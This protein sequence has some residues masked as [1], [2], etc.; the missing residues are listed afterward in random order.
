MTIEES[1][2]HPAP[3]FG[4]SRARIRRAEEHLAALIMEMER[5]I[6]ENPI[7][8]TFTG[9]ANGYPLIEI[10]L[11]GMGMRFGILFGDIVHSLRSSL[12]LMASEL[13]RLAGAKDDKVYFPFAANK[14]GFAAQI[15]Q[16]QFLSCGQDAV[17]L[18]QQIAPYKGGNDLLRALHDFDIRDKHRT[19]LVAVPTT[20]FSLEAYVELGPGDVAIRYAEPHSDEFKFPKDWPLAG[21]NIVSKLEEM[22]VMVSGIISKF[23]LM[24]LKRSGKP[25]AGITVGP[26]KPFGL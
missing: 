20:K 7:K 8:V 21:E 16:K 3:F 14:A 19:L 13:A 1:E 18:L 10:G 9:R 23:E 25:P 2:G 4:M 22:G 17:L 6:A 11:V 15:N 5:H 24:V 12:D 26:E